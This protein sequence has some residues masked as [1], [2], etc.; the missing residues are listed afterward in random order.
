MRQLIYV[1]LLESHDIIEIYGQPPKVYQWGSLGHNGIL[2]R[3]PFPYLLIFEQ[4]AT[5]NREVRD[6]APKSHRRNFQ[7][8][9]YD[10]HGAGYVRIEQGLRVVRDTL[11]GLTGKTSPTGARCTDI[12]WTGLSV[13]S[14]DVELEANVK[15]A[16]FNLVASQ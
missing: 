16:T 5:V 15:W 3:P 9:A 2:A 1:T 12:V 11:L 13:D 7:I 14:K 4:P 6:T 8:S 10:E